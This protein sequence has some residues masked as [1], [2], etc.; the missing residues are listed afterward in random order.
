M[1]GAE[2]VS[3]ETNQASHK[4]K[5]LRSPFIS[6]LF[7][8]CPDEKAQPHTCAQDQKASQQPA[9]AST[10]LGSHHRATLR[11][12]SRGQGSHPCGFLIPPPFASL[13]HC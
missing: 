10:P 2:L 12:E 11:G 13:Q 6:Q 8:F 7:M 1:K 5:N 4:M 3:S 9:A